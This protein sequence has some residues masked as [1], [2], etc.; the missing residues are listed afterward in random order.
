[1]GVIPHHSFRDHGSQDVI[2]NMNKKQREK[3][4]EALDILTEIQEQEQEKYDNSPESL[5]DTDR[6]NK[7]QDDADT[8]QEAIDSIQGV[9]DG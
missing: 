7:Y 4:Q 8:L 3:L 6:V 9:L 1:M 5:Q 2:K